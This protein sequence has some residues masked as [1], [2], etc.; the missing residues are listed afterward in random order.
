MEDVGMEKGGK[1]LVEDYLFNVLDYNIKM[2]WK[3]IIL[4]DGVTRYVCV[5]EVTLNT[6]KCDFIL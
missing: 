4:K 1:M 6:L 2:Y 3:M 5:N